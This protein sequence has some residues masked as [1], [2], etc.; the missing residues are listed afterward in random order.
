VKVPRG[1]L[2]D[3]PQLE[4]APSWLPKQ[5]LT[6]REIARLDRNFR[7]RVQSVQAIDRMLGAVRQLLRRLRVER[8]TYVIFSSDNG[9]HLGQRRLMEG[10]QG[11]WDHD[12]RVPLLVAGPGV[13]AGSN[14]PPAS[15]RFAAASACRA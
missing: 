6:A 8:N 7:K 1:V 2:F 4:G 11:A 10:K 13:P 15:M 12:I 3:A 5:P 9:F 14:S